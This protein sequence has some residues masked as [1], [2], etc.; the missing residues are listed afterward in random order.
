MINETKLYTYVFLIKLFFSNTDSSEC[1]VMIQW[2]SG[3]FEYNLNDEVICSGRISF[4]ADDDPTGNNT[5]KLS[6][7]PGKTSDDY[8]GSVSKEEIYSLMG[9][10][11]YDLGDKFRNIGGV[12]FYKQDVRGHVQ[13]HGDWIYFL[14]GLLRM[15]SLNDLDVRRLESP[16]SVR[17]I[18]IDPAA[19]GDDAQRRGT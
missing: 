14:D 1:Y 15:P 19:V 3:H 12:D 18:S 17:Q 8:Q 5:G 16:V 6:A 7:G 13:W 9:N 2:G 10:H 4:S 11:G